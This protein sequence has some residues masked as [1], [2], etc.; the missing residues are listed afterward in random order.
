MAA[1][2]HAHQADHHSGTAC[3]VDVGIGPHQC[4]PSSCPT[5]INETKYRQA[6]ISAISFV[7]C[8]AVPGCR[9][10]LAIISNHHGNMV[11]TCGECFREQRLLDLLAAHTMV[12][13]FPGKNRKI[14]E[15]DK[16]Y[17]H[18]C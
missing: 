15:T 8:D 17:L 5:G 9:V 16:T 14:F 3:V 1:T 12:V 7:R 4:R 2:E 11:S 18:G 13:V 6:S 10:R